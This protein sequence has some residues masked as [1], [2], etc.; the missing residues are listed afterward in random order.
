MTLTSKKEDFAIEFKNVTFGYSE[1]PIFLNLSFSIAKGSHLLLIGPNGGG[2]STFLKLSLGLLKPMQG[3]IALFGKPPS[4]T[5]PLVGY[6]PQHHH[7]DKFFPITVFEVV[8]TGML[9][10]MNCLGFYPK[11]AQTKAMETLSQVGLKDLAHRSFGALSGG[12]MQRVTLARAL[13]ND[14]QMLILDEPTANIDAE[15]SSHFFHLLQTFGTQK[16]ILHVTHQIQPLLIQQASAIFCIQKDILPIAK[17]QIC[18][19]YLFGLY[20]GRG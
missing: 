16:T 8:L 20:H 12:Q 15:N 17:E 7:L 19:H 9:P 11:W 13:V 10:H 3:S 5:S 14:P 18:N 4:E 6:V 2:K 1:D